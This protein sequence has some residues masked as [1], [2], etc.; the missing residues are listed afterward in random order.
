MGLIV[1]ILTVCATA[2]PTQCEDRH[3]EFEFSGS[4]QACA[5]GA[6]PYIAQWIGEH[7]TWTPMRWH[8]EYPGK[9]RI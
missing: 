3:F 7:P 9:Q 8:C 4:L 6:Q 2:Q 5:A 1:L